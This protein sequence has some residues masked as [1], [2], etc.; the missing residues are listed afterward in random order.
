M[1]N[2]AIC[3]DEKYF[4]EKIKE[5][6]EKYMKKMGIDFHIDLFSDG[7][8]LLKMGSDIS[9]YTMIFLDI[10]MDEI[11][12][13]DTA[14]KIREYN[15]EVYIIFVTAY[16]KYSLEGYKVN[17]IRYILKDSEG[18][19]NSLVECMDALFYKMKNEVKTMIFDFNEG[20]KKVLL[21][22]ILYIESHLHK[23]IFYINEDKL[24]EYTILMTLNAME[25]QMKDLG[26][27]RIHQS[28][29]VNLKHI[30]KIKNYVAYLNNGKELSIAKP[31][32]NDVK[33]AYVEYKGEL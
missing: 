8:E 29:L 23:L 33:D 32:Y 22:K 19:E 14:R 10:N 20:K 12:G 2:I 5:Y 31:R 6:I 1:V 4:R 24:N 28:Y 17:A 9:S 21:E 13:I 25:N 11:D 26:F 7:S 16:I 15:L 30:K 18:L 27:I 3:D